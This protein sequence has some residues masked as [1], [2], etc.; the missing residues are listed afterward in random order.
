MICLICFFVSGIFIPVIELIL[1]GSTRRCPEPTRC[2]MNF[3]S[4][5]AKIDFDKFRVRPEALIADKNS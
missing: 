1:S 4:G 5:L 3:T 2:P